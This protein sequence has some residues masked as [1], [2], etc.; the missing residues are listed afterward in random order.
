[1]SM[2]IVRIVAL[3]T[4]ALGLL[5]ACLQEET[6]LLDASSYRLSSL[7]PNSLYTENRR[8]E[9]QGELLPIRIDGG[10]TA[11]ER[12]KILRAVNEWNHVL[13]GH[14]R[15]EI[16]ETDASYRIMA[17]G[18]GAP[19]P[20]P[21]VRSK[22]LLA[23]VVGK[24]DGP[25][26]ALVF[27]DRLGNRDLTALMLHEFGHMLGLPHTAEGVMSPEY[28]LVQWRCVGKEAAAALAARRGLPL[29]ELNW[30]DA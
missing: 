25:M 5:S 12:A 7:Q 10:F 6:A 28:D 26:T 23:N 30:C 13:N 24:P 1:M 2:V 29:D 16:V 14:A 9:E 8:G 22:Y 18:V 3:A 4:G 20:P 21:G 11:Y 17:L 19:N 15:F 27:I